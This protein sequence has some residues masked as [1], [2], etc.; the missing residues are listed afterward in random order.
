MCV[1]IHF[2]LQFVTDA[3]LSRNQFFTLLIGALIPR[4]VGWSVCLSVHRKLQKNYKTLQNF[5]EHYK[6]LENDKIWIPSLPFMCED[7][8]GSFGIMPELP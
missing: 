4:S 8:Q 7:R 6:T 1:T 3:V 5:T 2:H